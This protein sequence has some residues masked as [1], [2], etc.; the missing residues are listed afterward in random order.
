MPSPY[1]SVHMD[2]MYFLSPIQNSMSGRR[3]APL[4]SIN[5]TICDMTIAGLMSNVSTAYTNQ[6]KD[7]SFHLRMDDSMDIQ[8]QHD[9][10]TTSIST[11]VMLGLG[12][13]IGKRKSSPNT[14]ITEA[15]P[16][17][18]PYVPR[19]M[20]KVKPIDVVELSNQLQ[21]NDGPNYSKLEPGPSKKNNPPTQAAIMSLLGGSSGLK[22]VVLGS[23][24]KKKAK[25]PHVLMSGS[26]AKGSIIAL[27]PPQ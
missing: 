23:F 17:K 6:T 22:P 10:S 5:A 24:N 3:M 8:D 20:V 18:R 7:T 14:S 11:Q 4:D 26:I 25:S 16:F 9:D 27:L 2:N 1:S 15:T 21:R 19:Q 13:D 12:K